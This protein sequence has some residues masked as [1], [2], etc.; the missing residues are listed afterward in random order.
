MTRATSSGHCRNGSSTAVT[1]TRWKRRSGIFSVNEPT[2]PGPTVA[3]RRLGILVAVVA[4]IAALIGAFLG[5]SFGPAQNGAGQAQTR[6]PIVQIVRQQPGLPSLADTIDHL[7]P[8][9]AEIVPAG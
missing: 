1:Q 2:P 3:V 5:R 8:S 4:A 7:C 6:R 9:I